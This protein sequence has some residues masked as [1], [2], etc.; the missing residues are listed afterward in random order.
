MKKQNILLLC[1]IL[2]ILIVAFVNVDFI[3]DFFSNNVENHDF[4]DI[5]VSNNFSNE[6]YILPGAIKTVTGNGTL[7]SSD[8][9]GGF[10][11]NK[12][13]TSKDSWSDLYDWSSPF[14]IEFNVID[15]SGNP[16]IRITNETIDMSKSFNELNLTKGAHVKIISTENNLTYI[17]DGKTLPVINSSLI[18]AQ[19]GFNLNNASVIYN[20]FKIY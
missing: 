5:G 2:L 4:V 17:I 13:D 16:F 12:E 1:A 7:V 10:Y 9:E 11:A 6:W 3:H 15:W 18:N 8:D 19:I 14:T 20:D